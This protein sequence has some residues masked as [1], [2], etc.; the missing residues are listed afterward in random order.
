MTEMIGIDLSEQLALLQEKTFL[1]QEDITLRGH[2]IECRINAEIPK[3]DSS[4]TGISAYHAPGGM[5]IRYS[6]IYQGGK[7]P[8]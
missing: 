3:P 4:P 6:S 7:Y 8:L 2:A 5:G 1:G